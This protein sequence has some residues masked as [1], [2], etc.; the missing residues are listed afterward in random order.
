MSESDSHSDGQK[1]FGLDPGELLVR[2]MQSVHPTAGGKSWE[3]PTPEELSWMLPQYE[4]E[5]LLGAGGMGAVYKGRQSILD[6]T[7][8]I[9]ILPP[10]LAEDEHFVQRF[11]REA[12]T[13]AKLQDA[14]IVTIYDFGQ[15]TE[16]HLYFVMEFVEGTD[17]RRLL[18]GKKLDPD[19]ALEL[20]CQICDALQAAH[21]KGVIHRDIKPENILIT[22]DGKVKLADFG[23]SRPS[24]EEADSKVTM[25][26]MVMGTPDYMSPEQKDGN[27][28]HR[29]DIYALGIV[30]YEMLTGK[31][32][33]GVFDP[34]SHKVQVDI[35]IDEIVL[36]AL[37]EEP[38]KRYQQV[39]ELKTDVNL[40]RSQPS[41][42]SN[43]PEPSESQPPELGQEA[44]NSTAS[45]SG[46]PRKIAAAIVL[47]VLLGGV[48]FWAPWRHEEKTVPS[49]SA[50]MHSV[51]VTNPVGKTA[52]SNPITP[53]TPSIAMTPSTTTPP[54][55]NQAKVG[56][57]NADYE[58]ST[59]NGQ[60]IITKYTGSGGDVKILS[61]INGLPVVEIGKESFNHCLELTSIT[62]PD[63]VTSIGL[64]AFEKCENLTRVAIPNSITNIGGLAF[65]NCS[66]LTNVT[67][68][69]SVY[70]ID[71]GAF[72][73]CTKLTSIE[74][75]QD[76][77][78]YCSTAEG[79]VFN[80]GKSSIVAYPAG[81]TNSSYEIPK[82]V[83]SIGNRAFAGCNNLATVIIPNSVTS[84]GD[85]SFFGCCQLSSITIPNSVTE[86]GWYAFHNT[87]LTNVT[88]PS[89]VNSIGGD[90]FNQCTKLK[91]AVFQG[92][93]PPDVALHLFRN[94]APDFKVYF[95]ADA[96]GFTSPFWTDSSGGRWPSEVIVPPP[97][98]IKWVTEKPDHWPKEVTLTRPVSFS[99]LV[100]GQIKGTVMAPVGTVTKVTKLDSGKVSLEWVGSTQTVPIDNTDMMKRAS[101]EMA[102]TIAQQA[103]P[104]LPSITSGK[105]TDTI[106]PA[107]FLQPTNVN[108]SNATPQKEGNE[109]DLDYKTSTNNGHIA[110]TKYIGHSKV[111]N[112]PRTI[113][114]LPVVAIGTNSFEGCTSLTEVNIPEGVT[115]IP[116]Y[117]FEGCSNLTTVTIPASVTSISWS[118]NGCPLLT[119][120][121]LNPSNASF[122]LTSD[123]VLLSK[124]RTELV[125]YPEGKTESSYAIPNSIVNIA[126]SAFVDCQHLSSI[127]IPNSVTTIGPWAFYD[128]QGLTSVTV[129]S[130]VS[131]IGRGAFFKSNHLSKV[132]F[133]GN[134]PT[135]IEEGVFNSC[136]S[137]FKVYYK[138]GAGGFDS[139]V[140]TY[141][142]GSRCPVSKY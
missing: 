76:N 29:T 134:A 66:S 105:P 52:S 32:P 9:K 77:P 140:W 89:S 15:T 133:E 80:R 81:K 109:S 49:I 123:G 59:N 108:S 7:V 33:R 35:R 104:R 87:S 40:F 107:P 60:I 12:R 78:R 141:S 34:P 26:N 57:L 11:K 23:L 95:K 136:A 41:A 42:A 18:H 113:N 30:F 22:M 75:D 106:A 103:T 13:L 46:R 117:A 1:L 99:I 21:K 112:I 129:P 61:S 28:D 48:L 70:M 88:I 137:D 91:S 68:P 128:C 90:A 126:N 25:T 132:L 3:P 119:S 93:K 116:G 24:V 16:G 86:I 127:T 10:E 94:A 36:K 97:D 74:V 130:S 96:T 50:S 6:R 5:G 38:E 102:R 19:Q 110:I 54:T 39:T 20:T 67:I 53:V 51:G 69:A 138:A 14:G 84:I 47:A 100:N 2:G 98:P 118:F 111:L 79:V 124:D 55:N 142:P 131:S 115:T 44:P 73:I 62:I 31:P 37:Q 125:R 120:L 65:E 72:G 56:L 43:S 8:A 92:N 114:G 139:P 17:L 135:T 83:I 82:S 121:K 64:R 122:S 101:E 27:T 63:S 71:F 58:T 4:I 45:E 85:Y